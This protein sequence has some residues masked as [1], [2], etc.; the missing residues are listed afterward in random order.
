MQ[1]TKKVW[2]LGIC[3]HNQCVACPRRK[4]LGG[5]SKSCSPPVLPS[6]S[7]SNGGANY[8]S[9][10]GYYQVMD[11]VVHFLNRYKEGDGPMRLDQCRE[12]VDNDCGCLGFFYNKVS[13][14][15]S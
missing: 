3:E 8:S 10:V 2:G 5:W 11:R 4:G 14:K 13:Y 12:S 15:C 6:W 1:I 7:N 9:S